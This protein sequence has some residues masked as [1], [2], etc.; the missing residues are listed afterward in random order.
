M[1]KRKS[2]PHCFSLIGVKT[3]TKIIKQLKKKPNKVSDIL[4]GFSLRQP[5]ISYHLRALEKR[6]IL[7]SKKQGR[8]I[9]YY[10]NKKYPCKNCL[11]FKM[12]FKT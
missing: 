10:L 12:S 7:C 1:E 6:G 8:E 4:A 9:Y 11:L 5:T 3:R 2:C